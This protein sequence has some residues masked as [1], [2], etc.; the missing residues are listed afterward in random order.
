MNVL[1]VSNLFPSQAEPTRG[2]FN[3]HQITHLAA[4]CPV[5]IVA[6]VAKSFARSRY[7]SGKPVAAFE[8]L[9]GLD[10]YHPASWYLPLIGRG[11]NGWLYFLSIRSLVR[12]IHREFP[13]DVILA[14]WAYPDACGTARLGFPYVASI[15]GSD[16][17]VGLTLP[18]RRRQI[19]RM[20]A[21]AE[22]VTTRSQALRDLLLSH[23]VEASRVHALYN[24][25]DHTLFH[26]GRLDPSSGPSRLAYV[27]RL[28]P[29]KGVA[30]LLDAVAQLPSPPPVV[31]IGDG[32]ERA[33]LQ[34]RAASLPVTWAG[35][36]PQGGIAPLLRA[37]DLF[38]QPSH[39]E[40]VPNAT[41]EAMAC[42]LPVVATRVGGLP[43]VVTPETGI[44]VEPRQPAALAKALREGL[45]RRWDRHAILAHASR[46]DWRL[47]A[48]TLFRVL[49]A[50]TRPRM[51]TPGSLVDPPTP[52][53]PH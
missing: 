34:R 40:G 18:M 41:L 10:V 43:E 42:G 39:M 21:G 26:P 50:A 23:G 46:F 19:L 20:L 15:S 48:E 36:T 13:I 37:S 2:V 33:R 25:V 47:N 16:A 31:I 53:R 14:N 28:A 9:G 6:P 30:D 11:L 24:G 35:A 27:G 8:K 1:F 49:A 4:R 12:Q 38:C 51:A 29:E 3:Y 22:A 7:V 44:L 17:N 5:R 32:P 52:P 45:A